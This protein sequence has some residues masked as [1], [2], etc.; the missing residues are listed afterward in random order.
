VEHEKSRYRTHFE[1]FGAVTDGTVWRNATFS[2][3]ASAPVVDAL[4][5]ATGGTWNHVLAGPYT[6]EPGGYHD[7][8]FSL[9]AA[10]FPRKES[11]ELGRRYLAWLAQQKPALH[12][13]GQGVQLTGPPVSDYEKWLLLEGIKDTLFTVVDR[14]FTAWHG[15]PGSGL[16]HEEKLAGKGLARYPDGPPAPDILV[17][18]G[19]HRNEVIA[20]YPDASYF[21]DPDTGADDFAGWRVYR[22]Q[23][24]LFVNHP[25]EIE[26]YGYRDW[27]LIADVPQGEVISTTTGTRTLENDH[28]NFTYTFID[29]MTRRVVIFYDFIAESGA[30]YYYAVSAY[31]D[32]GQN[33]FGFEPGSPMEGGRVPAGPVSV[34]TAGFPDNVHVEVVPNPWSRDWNHYWQ[35]DRYKI[36]FNNLPR[37]CTLKIYTETGDLVYTMEHTDLSAQEYWHQQTR[38]GRTVESGIY[39]LAVLNAKRLDPV[40]D[41]IIG[42]LP[43]RFVKF[44]I[45]R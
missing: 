37:L 25:E 33:L 14:S 29:G 32:G 11:V 4:L 12:P 39:I 10:D 36:M 1:S 7:M 43:D 40:T 45:I 41:A 6:L 27:D 35:T 21:D 17:K 22:K 19:P 26:Q 44:V 18:Q 13:K 15:G 9:A 16:S 42:S 34:G 23:G 28:Y 31:D 8:V 3:V 20:W 2:A 5:R 38:Y 30:S 24:E